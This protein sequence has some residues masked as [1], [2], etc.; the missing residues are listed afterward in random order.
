M[1]IIEK[2]FILET[3]GNPNSPKVTLIIK[4]RVCFEHLQSADLKDITFFLDGELKT[5][6]NISL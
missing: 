4:V 1:S 6:T 3:M 5:T 2:R